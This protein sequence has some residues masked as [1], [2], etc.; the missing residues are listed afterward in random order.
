[1]LREELGFGE[2]WGDGFDGV[3]VSDCGAIKN[4]ASDTP[5]KFAANETDAAALGVLAGVDMDCGSTYQSQLPTAVKNRV[6]GLTLA[7]V[8]RSLLRVLT[9]RMLLGMYDEPTAPF[10]S[11]DPDVVVDSSQARSLALEAAKSGLILL[12]NGPYSGGRKPSQKRGGTGKLLPLSPPGASNGYTVGV[13]GRLAND[14]FSQMGESNYVG[15]PP[16]TI[17]PLQGIQR[18]AA[19]FSGGGVRVLVPKDGSDAAAVAVAGEADYLVIATGHDMGVE[20]EGRD[21]S[22]AEYGLP[23]TDIALLRRIATARALKKLSPLILVL[24]NGM[25]IGTPWLKPATDEPC[26]RQTMKSLTVEVGALVE[27]LRGG[28]SAGDALA[29]LIFGDFSPSG[30]MPYTVVGTAAELRPYAE[31]DF[32]KG[33]GYRYA[34]VN[35]SLPPPLYLFG[36]GLS[37]ST[38][39]Y[40]ELTLAKSTIH[41][42]DGLSFEVTLANTG[43]YHGTEVVQVYVS[44]PP[45]FGSSGDGSA[46]VRPRFTLVAVQRTAAIDTGSSQ[47]LQFTLPARAYSVVYG[48]GKRYIEPGQQ[49]TVYVGGSSPAG[50]AADGMASAAVTI[51]APP[52]AVTPVPLVS[53]PRLQQ[54]LFHSAVA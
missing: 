38:W 52:T 10:A 23:P 31:M 20:N 39:N 21:R 7:D 17:T 4:M 14:S 15:K 46:I 29:A 41:P 42:C 54:V 33:R 34:H 8:D 43:H 35:A 40:S 2:G 3:V 32:T 26:E 16:Y 19:K 30:R 53:C 44:V 50:I 13:V 22:D 45:P 51:V 1:M 9:M 47:K 5:I 49:V 6:H 48:D 36:D 18:R 25:A 11:L 27:S 28:Q 12:E 24:V 37:F